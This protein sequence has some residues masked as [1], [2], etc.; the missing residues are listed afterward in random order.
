[1]TTYCNPL[2]LP[3]YQRGRACRA[4]GYRGRDYREMAD[5]TVIRFHGKWYLFPSSGM[6]WR[7]DDMVQWE[8]IPVEPF[9][10]G[11]APTV[12]VKG[13]WLYLSAS[14]DASA[15]WRARDP[16]G[17]WEKLGVRGEDADGNPTWLRDHHGQP[18]R[19]GDPCL[20]VD[21]DGALY[22]YCNL[23]QSK[24]ATPEHPWNLLPEIGI[25]GVRLCDDDVTRFA[26]EPRKLIEFN[27][28]HKWERS[29]EFN[30]RIDEPIIEGA[31]MT[32]RKGRYYLQYSAN[33]TEYRN[34]AVGCYVGRSPLGPFTPQLR[35]PILIHKGGL[36]NGCGHH[37]LVEGPDKRLW[38]FYTTLVRIEHPY[39]RRIGMDPVAFDDNDEMHVLGPTETPQPAPL[40]SPLTATSEL[41]S[42]WVP[43]SVNC[44]VRASSE[45]EGR[46]ARYA[47]DNAIRTWWQAATAL[48]PQWLE[49]DLE[50]AYEI[51]AARLL[52]ADR[53]L[54]W[55]AGVVP[56]AYA[57]RICVSTDRQQWE[58]VVDQTNSSS[59]CSIA[60]DV[61]PECR[62]RFVRLEVVRAPRGMEIALWE[63]TVFGA[64]QQPAPRSSAKSSSGFTAIGT[65]SP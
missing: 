19:W 8:H 13:D 23:A 56:G 51:G 39:E 44:P 22:C 34:Y 18:V 40:S 38:C 21:D 3:D 2:P 30:Q 1:M 41:I 37:S 6:L 53:G 57:Y 29:G 50:G 27:P 42:N 4:P 59:D 48:Q 45:V 10:P 7:S 32:K 36:V 55:N 15:I 35:N 63:F 24:A 65:T 61:W 49:V 5:P 58:T 47:V 46:E 20:F 43:L 14:W 9:D 26:A 52:F 64:P 33:A 60:Y 54:N 11:Y 62:A 16:L 28:A 12:V 25:Y 31:W 17:P